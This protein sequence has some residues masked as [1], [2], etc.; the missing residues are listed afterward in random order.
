MQINLRVLLRKKGDWWVVRGLEKDVAAQA[1]EIGDAIYE[2]QRVLMGHVF[3]DIREG[4]EPLV[5]IPAAP[6]LFLEEWSRGI[7]AVHQPPSFAAGMPLP[8]INYDMRVA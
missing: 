4:K 2:F 5:D 1:H 6:A 3:L 8:A 7:T